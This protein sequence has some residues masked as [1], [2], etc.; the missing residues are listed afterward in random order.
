M[1]YQINKQF[2]V[3]ILALMSIFAISQNAEAGEGLIKYS[4]ALAHE[5]EQSQENVALLYK[6]ACTA[7]DGVLDACL[8]WASIASD[9]GDT[10]AQ[11]RALSTALMIDTQNV[12]ARYE[13]ALLLMEKE[14]WVWAIEHLSV[15]L[16][17]AKESN[18][19]TL[20][21][22]YQGYAQYKNGDLEAAEENLST[23]TEN[24]EEPLKQKA[25]FLR[26]KI[27]SQLGEDDKAFDLMKKASKGESDDL[28]EEALKAIENFSAFSSFEGWGGQAR[29]S[30]GV[31]SHP[32]AAFLDEAGEKTGTALQSIFRADLLFGSDTGYHNRFKGTV[33][34]YREQNWAEL[35][36]ERNREDL[37]T[38]QDMNLTLFMFQA[39]YIR[40]A[41][42]IG[43][44]HE[45]QIA[46][47]GE[48]QFLDHL[49]ESSTGMITAS[50]RDFVSFSKALG[51]RVWWSFADKPSSI[52]GL[53]LKIEAR[54]N[55]LDDDNRNRS[56]VRTRLRFNHDHYFLSRKLQLKF[57][58]GGRW[59]VT[60]KDPQIIKYDRLL[61]EVGTNIK[62][63]TPVRRLSFLGGVKFK[64][65]WYL[66]SDKNAQNSFRP[67]FQND[68]E[69]DALVEAAH[70]KTYYSLTRQDVELELNCEAN[71]ALW[72]RATLALTYKYKWRSSN[73]DDAPVPVDSATGLRVE[74]GEYGYNQHSG[75]LEL[76]Q[77]F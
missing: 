40:R 63:I 24:L 41:R 8:K 4:L 62:W 50:K 51:G 22:Y 21:H 15:A 39:S 6:E 23:A 11:K 55:N 76:R 17:S 42:A 48:L 26:A 25:L 73:I 61:W 13:L 44:E 54:P 56:A 53:K 10:S 49:P 30:I 65:N 57:L 52:W 5:S 60:Y 33:T 35:G 36:E 59:D 75:F 68:P 43:M 27:A 19:K 7:D 38:I 34:V 71:V 70:E 14:D 58:A 77:A 66:N 1:T 9:N 31:N 47:D 16:S 45:L 72:T 64:H 12:L 28:N 67:A 37:Y 46:M 29:A 32:S 74:S 3:C 20:L 2:A 69:E 18:D